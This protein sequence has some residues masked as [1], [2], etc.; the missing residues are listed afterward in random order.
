MV[1]WLFPIIGLIA[2]FLLSSAIL[3]LLKLPILL[4]VGIVLFDMLG[5]WFGSL[6]KLD[7]KISYLFGLGLTILIVWVLYRSWL[8]IAI[9]GGMIITLYLVMKGIFGDLISKMTKDFLP[10]VMEKR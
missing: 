3:E 9:A 5:N 4:F 1:W 7:W 6:L 10:K 2:T 8:G